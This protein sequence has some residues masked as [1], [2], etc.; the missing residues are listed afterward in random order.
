VTAAGHI[1]ARCRSGR[2]LGLARMHCKTGSGLFIRNTS[3][4]L[5]ESG[6][7]FRS[8]IPSCICTR[9]DPAASLATLNSR[10]RGTLRACEG[11]LRLWEPVRFRSAALLAAIFYSG[12]YNAAVERRNALREHCPLRDNALLHVSPP[13]HVADSLAPTRSAR[14]RGGGTRG[15]VGLWPAAARARGLSRSVRTISTLLSKQATTGGAS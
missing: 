1:P 14:A 4:D 2:D 3:R 9:E 5:D 12:F 6:S 15:G 8:H 10:S 13:G 7:G 11:F